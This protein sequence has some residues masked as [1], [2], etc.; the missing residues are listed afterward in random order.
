MSPGL[1]GAFMVPVRHISA[2]LQTAICS[3][4]NNGAL[5]FQK[6]RKGIHTMSYEVFQDRCRTFI[7]KSGEKVSVEFHR[8]DGKYIAMFSNGVKIIGN[9]VCSSLR[10]M[11]GSGHSA[12][13]RA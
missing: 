9:S 5:G 2:G 11:W 6:R 4:M 1:S 13:A 8:G 10:V 12:I 3:A 7:D